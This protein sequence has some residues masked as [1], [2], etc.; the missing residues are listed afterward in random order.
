VV[1]FLASAA[2][3]CW[4]VATRVDRQAQTAV[5]ARQV[6]E[7]VRKHGVELVRP[8]RLQKRHSNDQVIAAPEERKKARDRSNA[9]VQVVGQH[10]RRERRP[11]HGCVNAADRSEQLRRA[12][13]RELDPLGRRNVDR[14]RAERQQQRRARHQRDLHG[15]KVRH[16]PRH[17]RVAHN[18]QHREQQQEPGEDC[19]VGES[20][21]HADSQPVP[22][23]RTRGLTLVPSNEPRP[24]RRLHA[25]I[26]HRRTERRH[27]SEV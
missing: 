8:H 27:P 13:A 5:P 21:K 16:P 20:R 7:L 3:N 15:G 23:R 19:R 2:C 14:K 24:L 22:G 11:P 10:N 6:R 12:F 26:V 4:P 9:G 17:D 18:Q 25:R 1:V